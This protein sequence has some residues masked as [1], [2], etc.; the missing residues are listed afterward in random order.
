M[1]RGDGEAKQRSFADEARAMASVP[2]DHV[3]IKMHDAIEWEAVEKELA[4][5]YDQWVGGPDGRLR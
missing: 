4:V 2:R 5:Y 1:M 3:L